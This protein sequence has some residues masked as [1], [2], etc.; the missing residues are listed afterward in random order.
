MEHL[1]TALPS[2]LIVMAICSALFWLG[3]FCWIPARR[4]IMPTILMLL[5]LLISHSVWVISML[6]CIALFCLGYGE[7]SPLRHC[8]GN[9]W[10]RGIW[11]L[12]A[13]IC[14]SLPLFLT[15]H[16]TL[17]FLNLQATGN[18]HVFSF[19]SIVVFVLYLSLNFT[20]EN[21]LKDIPQVIGDPLI[22]LGF[23]S[24]ILICH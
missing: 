8:F 12:L 2:K 7:K 4:F 23:S 1:L 10:G 16:L 11:G 22:G 3:G 18:A 6:S 24:I 5:C 14:L 21:A 15:H 17:P 20:L 19:Y 9:G 13:A